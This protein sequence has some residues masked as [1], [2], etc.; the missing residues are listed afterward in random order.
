MI[1]LIKKEWFLPANFKC[2]DIV[3]TFNDADIII[4]EAI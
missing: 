3:I 4:G 2:Y 1:Y